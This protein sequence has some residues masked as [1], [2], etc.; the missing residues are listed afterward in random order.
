MN[1]PTWIRRLVSRAIARRLRKT[2]HRRHLTILSLEDRSV[3]AI[4]TVLNTN[5]SGVGSLRDAVASANANAQ[6]DTIQF[7]SGFFSVPRTI[8]LSSG[9]IT[10]AGDT[11]LT[12]VTGPAAGVSVSGGNTQQVFWVNAGI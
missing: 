11:A 4:F 8:T 10:F 5:D 9:A 6:A 2:P 1:S 3:P 7:A 12:T